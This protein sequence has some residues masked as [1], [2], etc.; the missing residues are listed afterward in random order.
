MSAEKEE[1]KINLKFSNLFPPLLPTERRRL[2]KSIKREGCRDP[3]I[4]NEKSEIIDGHNRY[5]ICQEHNISFETRCMQFNSEMQAVKWILENQLGRR[6]LSLYGKGVAAIR[7]KDTFAE[8][9]KAN[10]RAGGG[11]VR[12]KSTEPV[13][14][15]QE[16]ASLAG[17][18]TNTIL[19]I[20]TIE[21]YADEETKE[22]LRRGDTSISINKVY[23]KIREKLANPNP[24]P[25]M[26]SLLNETPQQDHEEWS[27]DFP[28]EESIPSSPSLSTEPP[29]LTRRAD[30][31]PAVEEHDDI[32][33]PFTKQATQET[34]PIQ[35]EL[36]N[37]L[38]SRHSK[39]FS[40]E[41]ENDDHRL[42]FSV[43]L[44]RLILVGKFKNKDNR[45]ELLLQV[46]SLIE[47]F[48]SKNNP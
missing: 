25:Q 39:F 31:V 13:N 22:K 7:F 23:K 5:S 19:K 4:I 8:I 45:V 34:T 14:T 32:C 41:P 6:N 9:A 12:E 11:A 38:F 40:S 42:A 24:V 15:R 18:S 28:K 2:E 29:T 44:V 1:L 17:I 37:D 36:S 16:L 48:R 21:K 20:E 27:D 43:K 47:K 46:E 33:K 35:S 3:I 30:D 10:Q 26:P